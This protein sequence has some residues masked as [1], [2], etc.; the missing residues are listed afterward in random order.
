M[1]RIAAL[2]GL[3]GMLGTATADAPQR[4]VVAVDE[5]V[6]LEVGYALGFRCDDTKI[7]DAS[8]KTKSA[9][10][11]V[12]VVKGIAVGTTLCRVGTAPERPTVLLEVR[13]VAAKPRGR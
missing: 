3:V 7:L 2:V 4:L 12:F 6:E 9:T 8:M 1:L 5:T 10:T 11:N 13:V